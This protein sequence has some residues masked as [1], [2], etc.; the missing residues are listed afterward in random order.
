MTGW[1]S[2]FILINE[3][4]SHWYSAHIDFKQK[5]IHIYDSWS[6]TCLINQQKP[7]LQRKNTG[8]MLVSVLKPSAWP[9]L[10]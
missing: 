4:H 3:N 5:C 9:M 10:T 1:D 2:V 8:L 6:E 7:V